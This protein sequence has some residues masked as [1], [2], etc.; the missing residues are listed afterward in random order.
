MFVLTRFRAILI[1]I[2]FAQNWSSEHLKMIINARKSFGSFLGMVVVWLLIFT[3]I[4]WL[5][6]RSKPKCTQYEEKKASVNVS[7]ASE[8]SLISKRLCLLWSS[9]RDNVL[10]KYNLPLKT[11]HRYRIQFLIQNNKLHLFLCILLAGDI[12]V[13]PGPVIPDTNY[14]LGNTEMMIHFNCRSLLP[15]VDELRAA[16]ESVKPLFIAT[17]ETWLN[18]GITNTEVDISGYCL[19]RHDRNSRGGGVAIYIKEGL[20]CES[21]RQLEEPHFETLCIEFKIIKNLPCLLICAYRAP[22]QP[23]EPFI[24]YLDDVTREALRSNKQIIII[25]DLNCDYLDE[26]APQTVALKEF[27]DVYKL[28]QLIRDPTR[29]TVS[30][31]SLIDLLV[32]SSPK[33]FGSTGVLQSGFSDH[34]PIFGSLITVRQK[35]KHRVISTR[36]VDLN[37]NHEDFRNALSRISWDMMNIFDDPD[38][39]LCIWENLFTPVMNIFFPVRRKRIRKNS[40]PWIDSS[41]LVLMHNR[42][43]ARKKALKSKSDEEFNIYRRLRNCVTSRL[44]KAKSEFFKRKLDDCHR[45][46]KAFWKLMKKLLPSK[47]RT[48]RI[49]KLV[50]DGVDI[51]DPKGISD[52]LNMHFTSVASNLISDRSHTPTSTTINL[53]SHRDTL[54]NSISA[55]QLMLKSPIC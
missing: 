13:N 54:P 12:A 6:N 42:D 47:N 33:L 45:D 43:Q 19:E 18:K 50:V 35:D 38:D 23:V 22:K 48:T 10:R 30:S 29:T 15:K 24:D 37:A 26:S 51:V 3:V 44:R 21:K 25:G 16:F 27:L 34:L 53:D 49:D 31:E 9:T 20:K 40:Y 4:A 7:I 5:A 28:V 14:C 39:K 2:N 55:Q 17:T 32:T 11:A 36:K 8:L 41:I 52:S 46:P 1:V